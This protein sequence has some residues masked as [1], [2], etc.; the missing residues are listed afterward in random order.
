MLIKK[1]LTQ[2]YEKVGTGIENLLC[3]K[4]EKFILDQP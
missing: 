4:L 1:S 2:H 3:V